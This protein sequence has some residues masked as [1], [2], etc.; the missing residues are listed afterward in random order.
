[1]NVNRS[2]KGI[3]ICNEIMKRNAVKHF[4]GFKMTDY[5]FQVSLNRFQ[6]Y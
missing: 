2:L 4:S 1:M 5:L 6:S 3:N